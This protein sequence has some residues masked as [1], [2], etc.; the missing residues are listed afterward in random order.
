MLPEIVEPDFVMELDAITARYDGTLLGGP[1]LLAGS[2]VQVPPWAGG[3]VLVEFAN[4]LKLDGAEPPVRLFDLFHC[5]SQNVT[6]LPTTALR[7]P[8]TKLPPAVK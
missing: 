3:F 6:W 8:M 7:S 1:E 5:E 2:L 4:P